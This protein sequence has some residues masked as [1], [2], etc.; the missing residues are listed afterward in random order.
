MARKAGKISIFT[1]AN[2]LGISSATVSRVLN[3]RAGVSEATRSAVLNLARKY[4]FKLNYPPQRQPLI[5]TVVSSQGGISY[6]TSRI[7]S[8]VYDYFARHN[9]FRVNTI[10]ADSATDGSVLAAVREQQCSGVILIQAEYFK[11]QLPQL[12]DSGLPVMEINSKSE[13]P[14]IG[15]IDNDSYTGAAELTRHLLEL[16]HRRI[17]FLT[18]WAGGGNHIQRLKGFKETLAEAGITVPEHWVVND[19][20]PFINSGES[21]ARMLTELLHRDPRITAVIGFNDDLALGALHKAIRSGLRVPEDISIAG[22][23][24][25]HY[26]SLVIP[27]MTSVALP[28]REAGFRA[29]AAVADHIASNGKTVLPR[30]ILPT[31]LILRRSTGIAPE[32]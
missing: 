5:A 8:G 11:N 20:D 10:A 25:N 1:L 32:K 24:D 18:R 16:G 17:G 28:C 15:Y 21:G 12:A 30:E 14:G 23:D 29:A 9:T 19:T 4:N 31:C 13:I 3:N 2:E 7:L 22:F 27:E 26:S 6:Y